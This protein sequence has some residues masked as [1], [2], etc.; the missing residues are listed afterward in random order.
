[1]SDTDIDAVENALRRFKNAHHNAV[2]ADNSP[3]LSERGLTAAWDKSD[4][5]EAELRSEIERLR[6]GRA[7]VVEECAKVADEWEASERTER[8]IASTIRQLILTEAEADANGL[9]PH[10]GPT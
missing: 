8:G 2:S 10:A 4:K 6:S 7:A 3:H 5:A 9:F 1:M